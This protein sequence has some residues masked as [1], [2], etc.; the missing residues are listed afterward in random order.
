[1]K[2]EDLDK[3]TETI[4]GYPVKDLRFKPIDNIIVGLVQCPIYGKPTLHEGYISGQ[5][6]KDGTPTNKIKGRNDLKLKI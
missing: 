3:I 1:M 5:W 2:R 4:E 6:H